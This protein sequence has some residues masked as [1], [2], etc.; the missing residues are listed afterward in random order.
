VPFAAGCT[1][2]RN[3]AFSTVEFVLFIPGLLSRRM[4]AYPIPVMSQMPKRRIMLPAERSAKGLPTAIH[5]ED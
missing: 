5:K 1:F 4:A 3:R 2:D